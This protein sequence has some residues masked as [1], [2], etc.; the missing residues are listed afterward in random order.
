MTSVVLGGV[1][2]ERSEERIR[3]YCRIEVYR[4]R[5]YRGGYDDH[6]NITDSLTKEDAEAANNLHAQLNTLETARLVRDKEI[7]EKLV[8][9]RDSELAA[10]GDDEWEEVGRA[11][12]ALMSALLSVPDLDLA[13][14]T[15]I[16]H[17]KRPHL[18]PVLD[19][20]VVRFLT[21][22]DVE[23][24]QFTND[25]L[26]QI[27]A[28]CLDI[29]RSDLGK[30]HEAFTEL[31]TKLGDLPTPLPVVRMYDIL[32]WT[33]EKWINRGDTGG[34]YGEAKSFLQLVP[35]PLSLQPVPETSNAPV[36]EIASIRE[37]RQI[38]LRAEGVIV[39]T[40]SK[41]PRAH[42]SLCRELTEERF[43]E[44]VVFNEGKKG[45]YYLRNDLAE[46]VRDFGAAACKKCK[47]ERPSVHRS[48]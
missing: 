1:L 30:N 9:I 34:P 5:N 40:G 33:Q 17:L 35:T 18:F 22:N 26:I 41:P 42:R 37:F 27:G 3:E 48:L 32:C 11:V 16:L 38:K 36:G 2:I 45:R 7:A 28:E 14:A 12:R 6:L 15:K 20:A 44:A 43:Q 25:E 39:N 8:K 29:A 46:A 10:I 21:K 23:L 31:Q 47:P 19:P 13:K 24:N 4:D